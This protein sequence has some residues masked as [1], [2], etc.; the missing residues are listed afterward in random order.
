M[1]P[2]SSPHCSKSVAP[3][4][5]VGFVW[6]GYPSED[7]NAPPLS[8]C[9]GAAPRPPGLLFLPGAP[10]DGGRWGG[11]QMLPSYKYPAFIRPPLDPA[12]VAWQGRTVSVCQ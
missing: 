1:S 8:D 12:R 7:V 3:D 4:V 5:S 2:S 6:S 9:Y 11:A 10:N